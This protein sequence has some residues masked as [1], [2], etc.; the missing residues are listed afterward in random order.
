[1]NLSGDRGWS[2]PLATAERLVEGFL[3]VV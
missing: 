3:K 1:V 2:E